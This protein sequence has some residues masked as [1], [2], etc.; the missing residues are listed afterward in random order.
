MERKTK[1]DVML[2]SVTHNY[3]GLGIPFV[4]HWKLFTFCGHFSIPTIV[5]VTYQEKTKKET[6]YRACDPSPPFHT[7]SSGIL[8]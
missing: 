3:V 6:G 1:S 5:E 4:F 2:I 8:N 7:H